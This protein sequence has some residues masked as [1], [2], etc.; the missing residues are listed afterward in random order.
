MVPVA[1]IKAHIDLAKQPW[2]LGPEKAATIAALGGTQR[3][4]NLEDL[5][6]AQPDVILGFVSNTGGPVGGIRESLRKIAPTDLYSSAPQK[7]DDQY[8]LLR[9]LGTVTGRTKAAEQAI[10]RF[11]AKL[12]DLATKSPK[13]RSLMISIGS[14]V[15]FTTYLS[16]SIMGQAFAQVTQFPWPIPPGLSEPISSTKYSIEQ[17]LSTDPD[18]IF[19]IDSGDKSN[20]L[21]PQL[22]TAPLWG[23]P[24]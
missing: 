1:A 23:P 16:T 12:N 18:V 20:P 17:I 2:F 11:Q 8:N 6:T 21:V 10:T 5:A 22:A 9:T 7:I 24:G 13:N 19:I 3:E 15:N 14:N 4:P